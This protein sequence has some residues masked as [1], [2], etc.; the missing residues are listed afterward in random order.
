[1]QGI[2]EITTGMTPQERQAYLDHQAMRAR[3]EQE[4]QEYLIEQNKA[5]K[6]RLI[7]GIL[8]NRPGVWTK[9]FLQARSIKYLEMID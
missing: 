1:M 8:K 4:R 7:Q 3:Q 9:E 6:A 5:Y 2:N